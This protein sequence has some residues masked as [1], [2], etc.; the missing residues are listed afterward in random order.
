MRSLGTTEYVPEELDSAEYDDTSENVVYSTV[1]KS[2]TKVT[3]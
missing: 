3:P 1:K 2:E